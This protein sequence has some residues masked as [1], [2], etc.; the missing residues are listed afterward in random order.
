MCGIV[1]FAGQGDR[2]DLT[3]MTAALAH[4]GPDDEGL[5]ANDVNGVFLGHRRLAILDLAGG[6][7]PMWNE[8]GQIGIVF[9]GEIYNHQELRQQLVARGHVFRTDHSDTE[10]LVHGYEEWGENLPDRLNGMFAFA[11]YDRPRRRL[12]LARDRFGEKPLY[13]LQRPGLFAFASELT[14]LTHHSRFNTTIDV[15][16]LQ[17]FF[18]Y[19]YI[20]AP[21]ALYAGAR[22]LPGGHHLTFDLDSGSITVKAYWQ[23]RLEPDENI[24]DEDEPALAEELRHLLAQAV[25]RRLISD[26]PLGVFLSGGIDSSA[27][28]AMAAR[29]LPTDSIKTFTIG[30]TEPSFDESRFARGVA[31]RFDTKHAEKILSLDHANG[32]IDHVLNRLDEPMGDA[33][34]LPTYLL[35]AFTREHVTVALAGDGGDELFAGYDPFKALT[36]ARLYARLVPKFMHRGVRRLADLLPISTRNMSLDFKIRRALAGL[37]YPRSV[38]N[39]IWM[40]PVGPK[41]MTELFEAPV[42]VEDIY[43]DAIALWESGRSKNLV[44]RTLEFFTNFYLQDDILTKTD[45]AAMMV[46]LESRAIFLDNDLVEFCRR[47]PARFKFRNGERKYLLKRALASELPRSVLDRPKKGFG[48]PLTKWLRSV[49]LGPFQP[50]T[51]VNVRIVERWAREHRAGAVDHRLALWNW[52][53]LQKCISAGNDRENAR[54]AAA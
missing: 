47:L 44:D 53:S 29:F 3:A 50:V 37:S 49:P 39:P 23:F 13:Y 28:L 40:S 2:A 15:G 51:G 24:G 43:G 19:G 32:L 31:G 25:K 5:L 45:R 7:Q 30:F 17:K 35:S 18:A 34:I 22:K 48:I 36:P 54:R 52:L 26:V 46:S 20:P 10:A 21:H 9:N 12:F 41:E 42:R 8:D 4:R 14:A 11:I 6:H 16:A 33:S 38:W 27:V 1:G